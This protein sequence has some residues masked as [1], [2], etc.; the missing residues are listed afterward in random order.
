MRS[1]F[2][3]ALLVLSMTLSLVVTASAEPSSNSVSEVVAYI[4]NT[5]AG[6]TLLVTP[7]SNQPTLVDG[8]A[9]PYPGGKTILRSELQLQCSA[10]TPYGWRAVPELLKWLDH[11][12]AFVRYIAAYSLENITGLHPTFYYFGTPHRPFNGDNDWFDTAKNAWSKWYENRVHSKQSDTRDG[13]L[14][15]VPGG[16]NSTQQ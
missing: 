13:T 2:V 14:S 8:W 7:S 16:Q 15:F 1:K 3:Y 10:I 9:M 11:K 12:D 5:L 6:G 4:M